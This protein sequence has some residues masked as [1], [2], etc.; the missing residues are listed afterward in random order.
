MSNQNLEIL[1]LSRLRK[2]ILLGIITSIIEAFLLLSSTSIISLNPQQITPIYGSS[3]SLS[4][5]NG[6]MLFLYGILG[7]LIIDGIVYIIYLILIRYGF[8]SLAK[9]KPIVKIGYT[10][11]TLFLV[12]II[13]Y[14]I[15]FILMALYGLSYLSASG[16]IN[17]NSTGFSPFRN[18]GLVLVGLGLIGLGGL[19]GFIAF[20]LIIVGFYR[21]G[22]IYNVGL[23]KVGAI[24]LIIPI[25]NIISPFLL[26]FGLGD[27]MNRALSFP[28]M[29]PPPPPY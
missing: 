10:G 23:L 2:A 25:A 20:I 13:L 7:S 15:A 9:V 11:T 4:P 18:V 5:F 6:S 16:N 3:S 17:G 1:G 22:S 19:I 26:Y 8:K 12:S 14:I 21:I 27:A 28:S 29:P 24:L